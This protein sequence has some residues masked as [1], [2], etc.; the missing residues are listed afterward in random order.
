[1]NGMKLIIMYLSETKL[2]HV[3]QNKEGAFWNAHVYRQGVNAQ[4]YKK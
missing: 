3:I 1:M 4:A 2:I